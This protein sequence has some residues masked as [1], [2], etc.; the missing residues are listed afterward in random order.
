MSAFLIEYHRM[1]GNVT[2]Q[3]FDSLSEAT[4]ARILRERQIDEEQVEV[5]VI[6]AANEE[7]LRGSHSRYFMAA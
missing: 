4:R 2:V 5:V 7:E 3:L 1:G 6:A